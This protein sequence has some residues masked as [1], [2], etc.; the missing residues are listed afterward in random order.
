MT[1]RNGATRALPHHKL[2]AWQ[3]A[4]ELLQAVVRCEVAD[5][6]LRQQA[7]RAAK[8]CCLNVAEAAGRGS[9]ADRARVFLIARGECTE[10]A[11]AVE[12]ALLAGDAAAGPAAEVAR[13]ADR[14]YAL[15]TGLVR[16]AGG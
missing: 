7:V 3:V 10:A 13:L 14:A 1:D 12:I 2:V 5:A 15:L 4:V 11:A 16:R 8:S 6:N 9:A